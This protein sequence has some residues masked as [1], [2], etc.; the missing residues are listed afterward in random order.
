MVLKVE[1]STSGDWFCGFE[2]R[3]LLIHSRKEIFS[4]LI[5]IYDYIIFS[6]SNTTVFNSFIK[7]FHADFV[8]KDLGKLS[9]FLGLEAFQSNNGLFLIQRNYYS[10]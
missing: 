6:S 2:S 5:L 4:S 9:F 7:L 10:T 8:V 3:L 1:Q